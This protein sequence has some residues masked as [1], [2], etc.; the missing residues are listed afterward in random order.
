MQQDI[1]NLG[2]DIALNNENIQQLID[3]CGDR[4]AWRNRLAEYGVTYEVTT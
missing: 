2:L 3:I 4:N 1:S